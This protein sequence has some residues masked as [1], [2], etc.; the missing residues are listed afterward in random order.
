MDQQEH[1][2]LLQQIAEGQQR[3]IYLETEMKN[4]KKLMIVIT[5]LALSTVIL[6]RNCK[7]GRHS[8]S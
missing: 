3:L 5:V 7:N 4:N 6:N 2:K 8:K 1:L